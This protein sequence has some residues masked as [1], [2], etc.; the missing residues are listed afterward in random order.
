MKNLNN[1]K[2]LIQLE[3]SKFNKL[4]KV[5]KKNSDIAFKILDDLAAESLSDEREV[6]MRDTHD[7][8]AIKDKL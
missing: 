3:F 6:I 2:T 1:V 5:V 8:I 4:E 7:Y